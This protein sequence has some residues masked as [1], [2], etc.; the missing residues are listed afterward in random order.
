MSTLDSN[1]L[2]YWTGSTDPDSENSTR[3]TETRSR[4]SCDDVCMPTRTQLETIRSSRSSATAGLN[5]GNMRS[6]RISSSTSAHM[7]T[8][9]TSAEEESEK[10][11]RAQNNASCRCHLHS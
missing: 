4:S 5:N 11:A 9:G 10:P 2:V 3:D 8:A 6:H 7:A 1:I